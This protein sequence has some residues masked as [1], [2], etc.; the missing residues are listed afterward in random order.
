MSTSVVSIVTELAHLPPPI[1]FDHAPISDETIN[2]LLISVSQSPSCTNHLSIRVFVV[3]SAETRAEVLS[4]VPVH[5][6][7]PHPAPALFVVCADPMLERGGSVPLSHARIDAAMATSAL[8]I[9]ARERNLV[10]SIDH[11]V[12]HTEKKVA[13]ALDTSK[14]PICIVSMGYPLEASA[15]QT[16][17]R[18]VQNFA[19]IV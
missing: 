19:S 15:S 5:Q 7:S 9:A 4:H 8:C 13:Q 16:P 14:V 6:V 18:P 1:F 3:T 2:N 12:E 10:F 11:I 17:S